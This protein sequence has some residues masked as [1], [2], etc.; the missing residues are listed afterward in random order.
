MATHIDRRLSE[1]ISAA[2]EADLVEAVIV[3]KE[4]GNSSL[5]KD[6][7]GLV[8]QVIEQAI[9]RTSDQPGSVRYFPRANAA[10][11]S[12]SRRFIQEI[13]QDENLAVAS[14]IDV[15]ALI[16]FCD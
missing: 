8:Q 4:S 7:D 9:Q 15:D 11:I 12:A 5:S 14:A 6:D 2:G 16:F 10:V 1:K 3:V 13:L